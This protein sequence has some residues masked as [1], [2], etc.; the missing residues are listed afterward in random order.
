MKAPVNRQH[1]GLA[2]PRRFSS[3]WVVL[4]V[5]VAVTY[6]FIQ[7]SRSVLAGGTKRVGT[8]SPQSATM[9]RTHDVGNAASGV[10]S[11]LT[12]PWS[13]RP[14]LLSR[15]RVGRCC[16]ICGHATFK[17]LLRA[18]SGVPI[19]ENQVSIS[20]DSIYL[21]QTSSVLCFVPGAYC[22]KV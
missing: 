7:L 10:C 12:L 22:I 13:Q 16:F 21:Y 4:H 3:S 5:D 11:T 20:L 18:V 1:I 6:A 17:G 8:L 2:F 19:A 15:M 14:S 9:W